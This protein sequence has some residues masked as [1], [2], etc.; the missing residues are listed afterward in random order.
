MNIGCVTL[1]RMN[2]YYMFILDWMIIVLHLFQ[3]D[4]K[5]KYKHKFVKFKTRNESL[6]MADVIDMTQSRSI[7]I[8][9]KNSKII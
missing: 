1:I 5:S 6:K 4:I 2:R 8:F 7:E 9:N 3:F